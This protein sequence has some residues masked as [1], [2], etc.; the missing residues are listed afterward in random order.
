MTEH[1]AS[2]KGAVAIL[3]VSDSRTLEDDMNIA[4]IVEYIEAAGHTVM[5]RS[6]VKDEAREIST[7]VL[8]WS[9]SLE[10]QAIIVAGG[11][12]PSQRDI[13]P[14]AISPL[15]STTL[16]G[17]GELFR[18]LSYEQVGAAAMLSRAVAGWIDAGDLRTP[19][20]LLPGSPK[21][22][23]LGME[24]LIVPQLGHLLAVCRAKKTI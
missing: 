23:T 17:F 6:L 10:V 7:I 18:Q 16:P 2:I 22:V 5:H 12:G 20:F 1:E 4:L 11:T 21:A 15:F 3:S 14:D 13:T 9:R 19:V 24:K 8:E